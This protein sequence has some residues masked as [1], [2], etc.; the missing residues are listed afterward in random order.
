MANVTGP[1][2]KSSV[3]RIVSTVTADGTVNTDT[4]NKAFPYKSAR[5]ASAWCRVISK[6]T[7][8]TPA[9]TIK[10]QRGDGA[11]TEVFTDLTATVDTDAAT[12]GDRKDF[13]AV[14]DAQATFSR[15]NTLRI[16]HVVGGTTT[17]GSDVVEV[18]VEFV[19]V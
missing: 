9:N 19:K 12:A 3:I 4:W 18:F 14:V 13:T 17:T 15:G 10:L 6:R 8:G 1:A 2:L 16:V 7:G 5:V 11:A